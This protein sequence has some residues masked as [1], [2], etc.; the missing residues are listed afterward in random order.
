[1]EQPLQRGAA[2]VA[3]RAMLA[4]VI[5]GPGHHVERMRLGRV[6]REQARQMGTEAPR[7]AQC[8]LE[9]RMRTDARIEV[10]DY[11]LVAHRNRSIDG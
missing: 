2:F 1:M 3:L 9:A 11:A 6:D 8:E 7:D 5:G 4:E 10:H